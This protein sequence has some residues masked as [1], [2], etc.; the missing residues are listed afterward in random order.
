MTTHDLDRV[1]DWFD[2]LLV[3][4]R[5]VLALGTPREVVATGRVQRD[6]RAHAYPRPSAPRPCTARRARY[7]SGDPDVTLLLEPFHY[8]FMQRAFVAALA[9]GLLCSTMG[10]YVVLR[11]LSFIGDGIAHASF[12][13]IVI[14]YL[15][16]ANFYIGAAIV[17]VLTALG[18]GFV[19][20]RGRIS[21]DTTIGVL[22]T[23][24]FALGVFLMSQQRSYAVDLQSFLFGNIL[25]VQPQDL[26]L[27][28]G[29]EHRGCRQRSSCC[30]AGC[31]T[32]R[33]I[34]S[35]RRPAA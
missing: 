8:A 13:G 11:K 21:L 1:D 16:G 22:F 30:T 7:A 9:V 24:M 6:S 33:S 12:A 23:G 5:R 18:I 26:W 31:C 14:A 27:I 32:R 28:L 29:S 35:W 3:L 17:A 20:R 10:T 25:S 15:R 4:D 34:R 19:H 2:R